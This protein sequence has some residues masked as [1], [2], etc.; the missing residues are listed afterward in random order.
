M[1][2]FEK[3]PSLWNWYRPRHIHFRP[4]IQSS[5]KKN[6]NEVVIP[7]QW[8]LGSYDVNQI[9]AGEGLSIIFVKNRKP[10]T[11]IGLH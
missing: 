2:T 1:I 11:D 8:V 6:D 4:P 9:A 5:F 3:C 10:H 7:Y